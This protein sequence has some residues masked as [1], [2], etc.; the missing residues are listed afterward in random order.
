MLFTAHVRFYD[1]DSRELELN[2]LFV[3]AEDF[4]DVAY[5][6]SEYYGE[7]NIE[8]VEIQAFSPDEMLVF[9]TDEEETLF[10]DVKDSLGEKVIW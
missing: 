1:E 6:V 10:Y 3:F 4:S 8:S 9:Q 2:H 5:K 7:N